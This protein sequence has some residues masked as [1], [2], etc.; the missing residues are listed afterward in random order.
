MEWW[1]DHIRI[2]IDTNDSGCSLCLVRDGH[3]LHMRRL[4]Q[5]PTKEMFRLYNKDRESNDKLPLIGLTLFRQARC[6]CIHYDRYRKCV[7]QKAVRMRECLETFKK[8][9]AYAAQVG[10]ECSFHKA[11]DDGNSLAQK[12]TSATSLMEVLLCEPCALGPA[13]NR[14][15]CFV[16]TRIKISRDNIR[17]PK[18]KRRLNKKTPKF[19]AN[20]STYIRIN[21]VIVNVRNASS[22]IYLIFIIHVIYL[23]IVRTSLSTSSM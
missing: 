3:Q 19:N 6:P 23:R 12:M 14:D 18:K 13:A 15:K 16:I 20:S 8:V 10:C 21:V 1:L 11:G 9:N 4:Q 5:L 7:D 2:Q 22:N 17:N